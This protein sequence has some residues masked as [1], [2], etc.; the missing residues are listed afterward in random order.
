MG[1]VRRTLSL[2]VSLV[3]AMTLAATVLPAGSAAAATVV[4]TA[5]GVRMDALRPSLV[6]SFA[7]WRGAPVG[8]A[9]EFLP[10]GTWA[11]VEGSSSFMSTWQNSPYAGEMLWSVGMLPNDSSTTLAAGASGA[12]DAHWTTLAQHLVAAGMGTSY[13]RLGWEMNGSWYRWS[14][15]GQGT[16]YAD[17]FRRIV[18]AMRSVPGAAFQFV[19]C[20]NNGKDA[21]AFY[22]GDDVVDVVAV[23]AYDQS[24]VTGY[25]DD[26][27]RWTDIS[28]G[29]YGLNYW[30]SFAGTHGK[31]VGLAEWGV[32]TRPDGHGGGDSPY[33]IEHMHDWIA[34]HDVAFETYFNRKASDGDHYLG[35]DATAFPKAAAR[36]RA[37]WAAA[38]TTP[39]STESTPST[40]TT[41]STAPTAATVVAPTTT[42]DASGSTAWTRHRHTRLSTLRARPAAHWAA[43]CSVRIR[44]SGHA[45]RSWA[46]AA[47]FR[48]ALSVAN[49]T[50]STRTSTVTAGTSVAA[51]RTK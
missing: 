30:A 8:I 1:V 2:A 27:T 4:P 17:Y 24:W 34:S 5:S 13:I 6:T 39:T 49:Q 50:C 15:A 44:W 48:R 26:A 23:D 51:F 21:S 12:Y 41:T 36:Y 7:D 45:L 43:T 14:A 3:T 11:D 42:V 38:A 32:F 22:P 31:K 29:K 10:Y 9:H 40:D 37:L 33:Y 19:W 47:S 18:A 16:S 25:S 35:P 46:L 28:A 20:P